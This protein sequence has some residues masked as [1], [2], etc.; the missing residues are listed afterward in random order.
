MKLSLRRR[1][2]LA[3][4]AFL[5]VVVAAG[6]EPSAPVPRPALAQPASVTVR[7]AGSGVIAPV[8]FPPSVSIVQPRHCVPVNGVVKLSAVVDENGVP[9]SIQTLHSDD[10]RLNDLAMGLAAQQRFKP[11]TI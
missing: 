9:R 11:G 8:L 1:F 10:A 5:S 2:V 4:A 3:F 7:Y 6:Q